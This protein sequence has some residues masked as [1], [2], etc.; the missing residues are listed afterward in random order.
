M[1]HEVE[2]ANE[3]M[4]FKEIG[5]VKVV[6]IV[7]LDHKPLSLL[8]TVLHLEVLDEF[9]VQRVLDHLRFANLRPFVAK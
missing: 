7:Y 1:Q 6:H 9:W 3:V 8:E 4:A 2:L 5:L